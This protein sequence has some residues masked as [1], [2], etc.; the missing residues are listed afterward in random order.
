MSTLRDYPH[1]PLLSF[2][3]CFAIFKQ[4]RISFNQLAT[5]PEER[6]SQHGNGGMRGL[7]PYSRQAIYKWRKGQEPHAT[8]L[9]VVSLLAYKVLYLLRN[10]RLPL[11]GKRAKLDTL[12]LLIRAVG[13]D[14]LSVD[15]LP[16]NWRPVTPAPLDL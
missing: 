2:V 5:R 4:A 12:Q 10:N 9:N 8:T 15:L 13:A 16:A 7:L 14:Q 11:P 3:Q 6:L 1:L